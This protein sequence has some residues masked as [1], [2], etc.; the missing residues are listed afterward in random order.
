MAHTRFPCSDFQLKCETHHLRKQSVVGEV[1]EI[2]VY[3][4]FVNG[5]QTTPD[6]KILVYRRDESEML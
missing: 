6:V 3:I 4:D 5:H 2:V 1:H